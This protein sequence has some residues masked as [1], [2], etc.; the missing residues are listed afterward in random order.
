M[1]DCNLFVGAFT[2]SK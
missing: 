1:I 2:H